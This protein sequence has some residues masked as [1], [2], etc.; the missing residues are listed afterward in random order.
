MKRRGALVARSISACSAAVKVGGAPN[1]AS[2]LINEVGERIAGG[3]EEPGR[4][5]AHANREEI[6]EVGG[7]GADIAG[8]EPQRGVVLVISD[9]VVA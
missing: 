1:S 9:A 3:N 5:A 7:A 4:E 8:L 6:A 2:I